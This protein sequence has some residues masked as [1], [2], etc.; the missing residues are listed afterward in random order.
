MK[1]KKFHHAPSVPYF[2]MGQTS[3]T[4]S[5]SSYFNAYNHDQIDEQ[6]ITTNF[7]PPSFNS[8]EL[9]ANDFL[10]YF[11]YEHDTGTTNVSSF[12]QSAYEYYNNANTLSS[13]YSGLSEYNSAMSTYVNIQN[14]SDTFT[15]SDVETQPE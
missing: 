14:F 9:D 2:D 8:Y 12:Y 15:E 3:N 11:N 6:D 5:S 1:P 10:P 4:T 7:S 13:P